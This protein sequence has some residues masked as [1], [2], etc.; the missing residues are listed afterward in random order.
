MNDRIKLLKYRCE[1]GL[2]NKLSEKS[3]E[4]VRQ[5]CIIIWKNLDN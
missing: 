4:L 1:A 3:L 5:K 2:G